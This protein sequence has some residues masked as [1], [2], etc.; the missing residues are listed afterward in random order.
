MKHFKSYKLCESSE[1]EAWAG[2]ASEIIRDFK[3]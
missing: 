1:S 2:D 3:T